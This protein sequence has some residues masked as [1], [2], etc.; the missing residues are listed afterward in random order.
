EA[1]FR[2]LVAVP[3][4]RVLTR[5]AFARIDRGKYGLTPRRANLISAQILGRKR[6]SAA[7]VMRLGNT[8][9]KVLG[10]RRSDFDVLCERLRRAGAIA[11]RMTGSGSAVVAV[12]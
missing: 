9:E 2:A 12:L 8:F 4:W 1:P 10:N 11:V 5:L 6:L 7:T 3:D